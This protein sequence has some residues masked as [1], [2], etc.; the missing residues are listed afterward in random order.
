VRVDAARQAYVVGYTSSKN[1]PL[2]NPI[3]STHGGSFDIFLLRYDVSG[4]PFN[5]GTYLGGVG[6]ETPTALGLLPGGAA[7]IVGVTASP[8]YPLVTPFQADFGG[9]TD[10]F[11]TKL[12]GF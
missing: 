11:I 7:F 9:A 4:F 10:G 6:N 5:F 8:N 3:Q 2:N 1:L 12:T